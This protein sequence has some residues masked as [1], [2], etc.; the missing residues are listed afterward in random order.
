M[1][2]A[3]PE[4]RIKRFVEVRSCDTPRPDLVATVACF[5]TSLLYGNL[6]A[7][8]DLFARVDE[9]TY[10]EMR[11]AAIKEGLRGRAGGRTMGEW[12]TALLEIAGATATC[13]T[14]M[15]ILRDRAARGVTPADDAAA[16]IRR[17]ISPMELVESFASQA[18][19]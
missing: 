7:V 8:F 4:A 16:L 2:Q 19:L 1:T 11:E 17:N 13:R 9:A 12:A 3:F 10:T 5:W 14:N 18:T 15:E 6:D